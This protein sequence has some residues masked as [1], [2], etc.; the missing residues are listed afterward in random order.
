MSQAVLGQRVGR[1]LR[2]PCKW[3][4][5]EAREEGGGA[6][7]T[8]SKQHGEEGPV[9]DAGALGGFSGEQPGSPG[10]VIRGGNLEETR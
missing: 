7:T 4:L 2:C 9:R 10:L 1:A 8:R 6:E 5:E 3:A